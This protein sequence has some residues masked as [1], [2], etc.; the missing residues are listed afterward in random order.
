M[1]FVPKLLNF[2]QKQHRINTAEE[3]LDSDLDDTKGTTGDKLW[4]YSYDVESKFQSSIGSCYTNQDRKGFTYSF[5]R[6]H[7]KV[8]RSITPGFGIKRNWLLNHE[9]APDHTSLLVPEFVAKNM[10]F[11]L[12]RP[13]QR[14]WIRHFLCISISATKHWWRPISSKWTS[15]YV[16]VHKKAITLP[17]NGAW[18]W[19]LYHIRCTWI[20]VKQRSHHGWSCAVVDGKHWRKTCCKS[21]RTE[22]N[23]SI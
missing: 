22:T 6:F 12:T 14:R 17:L 21:Y 9:N 13:Y 7:E 16:E 23:K 18:T 15:K 4:V 10:H 2:V 3:L 20:S 1:K 8:E 19:K 11:G 5:F